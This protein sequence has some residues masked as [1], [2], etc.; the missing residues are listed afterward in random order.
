M[1]V[2]TPLIVVMSEASAM[3]VDASTSRDAVSIF[4]VFFA[5]ISTLSVYEPISPSMK[6]FLSR[7]TSSM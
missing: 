7:P 6:D 2:V 4:T 5:K 1:F 3:T